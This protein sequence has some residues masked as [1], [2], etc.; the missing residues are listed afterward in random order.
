MTMR[1]PD[2]F[3]AMLRNRG[4]DTVQRRVLVSVLAGSQQEA[5]LSEPVVCD[6]LGRIRHF[7]QETS[8]GWPENPLPIAP[9]ARW[10]GCAATPKVMRALVYQNAVC[11]WRCWYCFVPFNLLAGHPSRSRW[12]SAEELVGLYQALPDQDRPSVIDLSGGQPD[13]VPEW[14]VWM[15][16]ALCAAGLSE[17]V[18]LWSDDNLSNDYLF[19]Y[20][21]D[22][23]LTRLATAPNYG[24][25][26][27]LKGFDHASFT[28]NTGAP[29]ELFDR[30]FTVLRR[31]VNTGMDVYCYAT[32]T[33]P[34]LPARPVDSMRRFAD[35][36]QTIDERL[37]LRLVPLEIGVFGPVQ[38]RLRPPHAE[39][40]Q[41]QQHMVAAWQVVLA[42]RFTSHQ[43]AAAIT[44]IRFVQPT[45]LDGR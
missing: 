7:H 10:L 27:C 31:I 11:N 13:L 5:D 33:T 45:S 26:G 17:N 39:S 23:Q 28:F 40:L 22:D 38:P 16:E 42:E 21:T 6:G 2:L 32:F 36:L 44:D 12:V 9:A 34:I 30:Q 35:R 8:P 37:P 24:R 14:A 3:A 29:A 25:V 4:V 18:Y 43:R 41:L 19:R 20:L 15:I 1:D